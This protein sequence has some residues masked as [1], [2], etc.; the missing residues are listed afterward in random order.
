MPHSI[1]T[2]LIVRLHPIS[3]IGAPMV[4]ARCALAAAQ[5]LMPGSCA[6]ARNPVEVVPV[7]CGH[8]FPLLQGAST[9]KARRTACRLPSGRPSVVDFELRWALA[10]EIVLITLLTRTVQVILCIRARLRARRPWHGLFRVCY[11]RLYT[12]YALGQRQR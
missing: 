2:F 10:R 6:H 8:T 4:F 11:S 9:S 1:Y 5:A 12:L 7:N 3:K